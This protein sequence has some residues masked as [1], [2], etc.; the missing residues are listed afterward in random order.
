MTRPRTIRRHDGIVAMPWAAPLSRETQRLLDQ[1]D[2]ELYRLE[3]VARACNRTASRL[4][5]DTVRTVGED[6]ASAEA[7]AATHGLE[8]DPVLGGLSQLYVVHQAV[9]LQSRFD[10][11]RV[12]EETYGAPLDPEPPGLLRSAAG[13][14]GR[15][16]G[17]RGAFRC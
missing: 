15:G 5:L 17:G 3:A 1:G 9:S 8:G 2:D 4:H 6:L 7:E 16:R 12:A 14:L 10:R 11:L 13:V